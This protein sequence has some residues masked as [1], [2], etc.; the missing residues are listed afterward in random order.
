MK[1]N[2]IA[3]TVFVAVMTTLGLVYHQYNGTVIEKLNV[4]NQTHSSM[5]M[6]KPFTTQDVSNYMVYLNS[7]GVNTNGLNTKC[8]LVNH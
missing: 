4:Y 5:E 1:N 3:I 6:N 7:I 8:V 2:V